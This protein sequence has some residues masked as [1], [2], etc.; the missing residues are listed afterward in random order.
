MRLDFEA[1]SLRVDLTHICMVTKRADSFN[2]N[3][4]YVDVHTSYPLDKYTCILPLV[5]RGLLSVGLTHTHWPHSHMVTKSAGS[6]L[7]LLILHMWM[8]TPAFCP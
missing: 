1:I 4:T 2:Q 3:Q 6:F 7:F 5:V 8:C